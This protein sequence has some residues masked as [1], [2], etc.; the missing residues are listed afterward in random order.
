M[1]RRRIPLRRL[2]VATT[3]SLVLATALV[4]ALPLGSAHTPSPGAAT[5]AAP[6]KAVGKL[7]AL[8]VRKAVKPLINGN[9]GSHVRIAVAG[10]TGGTVWSYGNGSVTPASTMK[11]LTAAAALHLMGPNSRITTS[12]VD[13]G[14]RADGTHLIVLKGGGDPLLTLRSSAASSKRPELAGLRQLAHL[15]AR[16]LKAE[17]VKRVHLRFDSSLFSKPG[18]A[19]SWKRSYATFQA[20]VSALWTDEGMLHGRP[21]GNPPLHA[22]Q[23]F[24]GQLRGFGIKVVGSASG[25]RASAT[26]PV[27]ASVQSA[28]LAAQIKWMLRWSDNA[29]AEVLAHQLG[30]RRDQATFQGGAAGVISGLK[31]LGVPT[32]GLYIT[33]GS[34]LAHGD[35]VTPA[36]LISV[37][38]QAADPNGDLTPIALGLPVAGRNG[39]LKDRFRGR[40]NTASRGVVHAKTGSLDGVD[41]LAGYTVDRNGTTVVF[42]AIADRAWSDNAARAQLDKIASAL[43]RCSCG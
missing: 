8:K 9:L 23:V 34:G 28:T 22:A 38:Q 35:R 39:T 3:A 41:A 12:V 5:A 37:L 6:K 40:V 18:R 33:D 43:T 42:V 17:G 29:V 16:A 30:A 15:S 13:K 10:T 11:L 25:G 19:S 1:L 26:A 7:S 36:A 14:R 31:Q 21:E 2:L 4:V 32:G 20:P 24:A 27:I